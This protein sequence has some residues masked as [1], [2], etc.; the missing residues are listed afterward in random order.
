M[1]SGEWLAVL[2]EFSIRNAPFSIPHRRQVEVEKRRIELRPQQKPAFL[3]PAE[4]RSGV[5]GVA[6]ECIEVRGGIG[7][8][9]HR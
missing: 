4:R 6:G 1:A 5:A 7:V 3:V 9:Q 8:L 2:V